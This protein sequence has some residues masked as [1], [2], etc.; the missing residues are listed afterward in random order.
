LRDPAQLLY[1]SPY[2]QDLKSFQ[3][4]YSL[5]SRQLHKPI[6][7]GYCKTVLCASVLYCTVRLVPN[8]DL[9]LVLV[10]YQTLLTYI[11]SFNISGFDSSILPTFFQNLFTTQVRNLSSR[12]NQSFFGTIRYMQPVSALSPSFFSSSS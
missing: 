8:Q 1:N 11:Y 5:S 12:P 2:L 7:W 6:L 9:S 3:Y 10:R 4:I